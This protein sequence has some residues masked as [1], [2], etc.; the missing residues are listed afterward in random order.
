METLGLAIEAVLK[1]GTFIEHRL[2]KS[3]LHRNPEASAVSPKELEVL[4]Q[5]GKGLRLTD[6]AISMN[7]S[8]KTVLSATCSFFGVCA[9]S[10]SCIAS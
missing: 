4:R 1:G 2:L 5:M 8:I 7:L 10:A 6:I 3:V 9:A